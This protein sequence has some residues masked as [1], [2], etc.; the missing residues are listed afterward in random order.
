MIEKSNIKILADFAK[1]S[2]RSIECKEQ[3]Y[4]VSFFRQFPR[5]RST[6]YIPNNSKETSYFIWFSDPYNKIGENTVYCGTFIPISFPQE[7]KINIRK[8]NFLDIFNTIGKNRVVKTGINSFDSKVVFKGENSVNLKRLLT[9]SG[10]QA[11][12][13]KSFEVKEFLRISINEFN[14]D[15]VPGLK[16]KSYLSIIN[17]QSWFMESEIIEK[18]FNSIEKIRTKLNKEY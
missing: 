14:L 11:E 5:F 7:L 4:P 6:V 9:K 18:L 16:G 3:Q 1:A 8:K 10:I 2:S 13:L 15:F 12:I 17:Q